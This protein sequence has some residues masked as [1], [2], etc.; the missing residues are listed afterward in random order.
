MIPTSPIVLVVLEVSLNMIII[1]QKP[2][3]LQDFTTSLSFNV[4]FFVF[5]IELSCTN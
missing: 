5:G 1:S 3:H 4:S 2:S